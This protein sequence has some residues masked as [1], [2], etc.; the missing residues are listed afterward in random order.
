MPLQ[1]MQ[2]IVLNLNKHEYRIGQNLT[3]LTYFLES[4]E[5]KKHE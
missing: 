2:G 3:I 4:K 1:Y 5:L